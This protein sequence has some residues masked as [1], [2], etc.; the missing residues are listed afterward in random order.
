MT[1]IS[2]NVILS[3]HAKNLLFQGFRKE[4]K[5]ILRSLRSSG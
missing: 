2:T 1:L 5:Q 3:D 4:K